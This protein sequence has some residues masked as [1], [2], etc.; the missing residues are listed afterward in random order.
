[1]RDTLLEMKDYITIHKSQIYKR[2]TQ[3]TSDQLSQRV[4][5]QQAAFIQGSYLSDNAP[6]IL[7]PHILNETFSAENIFADTTI[8]NTTHNT[9]AGSVSDSISQTTSI[10][11]RSMCT[12]NTSNATYDIRANHNHTSNSAVNSSVNNSAITTNSAIN[13]SVISNSDTPS[14]ESQSSSQKSQST[15]V[16]EK[17]D[18]HEDRLTDDGSNKD[19]FAHYVDKRKMLK[20]QLTGSPVVALCG[21]VWK[22]KGD[23]KNHPICPECKRI[24]DELMRANGNPE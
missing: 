13:N 2:A 11:P 8:Y 18:T 14:T 9:I 17:P 5:S 22:P 21:K 23:P 10:C 6:H 15:S 16:L 24:F 19:R 20:A 7:K 3:H 12:N 4:D 1:M